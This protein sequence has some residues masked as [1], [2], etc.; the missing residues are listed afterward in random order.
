MIWSPPITSL[1]EVN[2]S[3]GEKSREAHLQL[4]FAE[5]ERSR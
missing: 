2:I 4:E 5:A 3:G 1:A